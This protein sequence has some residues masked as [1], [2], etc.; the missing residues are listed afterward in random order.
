MKSSVLMAEN[1]T[2]VA[3][4]YK[5]GVNISEWGGLYSA[6]L[7]VSMN[8]IAPWKNVHTDDWTAELAII[9]RNGHHITSW[10]NGK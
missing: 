3:I 4:I 5:Y 7:E 8:K 1:N 6:L 10:F 2:L 9:A